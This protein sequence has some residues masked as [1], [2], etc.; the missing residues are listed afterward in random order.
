VCDILL[1]GN[2]KPIIFEHA[3]SCRSTAV[4]RYLEKEA[5]DAS[6]FSS[7]ILGNVSIGSSWK[8]RRQTLAMFT[9]SLYFIIPMNACCW[10][11]TMGL[12]Y[13]SRITA[14]LS[15]CYLGFMFFFD[16]SSTNG[17]RRPFLRALKS[18]G[19]PMRVITFPYFSSRLQI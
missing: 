9:C 5:S 6:S 11:A 4:Q 8:V 13:T 16:K 18:G 1:S 14:V 10:V 19:G 15:A 7:P 3:K 17:S 2:R 12:L